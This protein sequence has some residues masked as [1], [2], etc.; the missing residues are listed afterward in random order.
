VKHGK[1]PKLKQLEIIRKNKMDPER[2]LVSKVLPDRLVCIHR[3]TGES[4]SAFLK[5]ATI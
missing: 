4:K 5:V 3:L 1:N 2:W